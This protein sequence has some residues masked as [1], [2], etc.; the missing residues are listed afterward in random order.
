M[1]MITYPCPNPGCVTVN[2]P[3]DYPLWE[4]QSGR[5]KASYIAFYYSI[6]PYSPF[7]YMISN[8][9]VIDERSYHDNRICWLHGSLQAGVPSWAKVDDDSESIS[10]KNWMAF[11]GSHSFHN[12]Y[13]DMQKRI[14]RRQLALMTIAVTTNLVFHHVLKLLL[15]REDTGQYISCVACYHEYNCSHLK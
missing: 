7:P 9:F 2:K 12:A 3:V 15:H 10:T 13:I 8:C 11:Y 6:S 5:V 4:Y 1:Y 14:N